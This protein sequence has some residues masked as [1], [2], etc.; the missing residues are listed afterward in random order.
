MKSIFKNY[1]ILC[2]ISLMLTG[3][4]EPEEETLSSEKIQV[5]TEVISTK[6]TPVEVRDTIRTLSIELSSGTYFIETRSDLL[7]SFDLRIFDVADSLVVSKNDILLGETVVLKDADAYQVA[8]IINNIYPNA[9]SADVFDST[10]VSIKVTKIGDINPSLNGYWYCSYET[11]TKEDTVLSQHF[12]LS[13]GPNMFR[14]AGDSLANYSFVRKGNR[15]NVDSTTTLLAESPFFNEMLNGV[16]SSWEGSNLVFTYSYDDGGVNLSGRYVFSPTNSN[17]LS[18][19]P[20][21]DSMIYEK[22]PEDLIGTWYFSKDI[23]FNFF[24]DGNG[25]FY[26]SNSIVYSANSSGDSHSILKFTQDS[27]FTFQLVTVDTPYTIASRSE[28]WAESYWINELDWLLIHEKSL[29]YYKC[30]DPGEI[31]INEFTKFEGEIPPLEWLEQVDGG[32]SKGN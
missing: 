7:I 15:F 20:V 32:V 23:M 30:L 10:N 31:W 6:K 26:N 18:L 25:G 14:L 12:E 21:V 22:V 4:F 3:C 16:E 17:P 1:L 2:F 11:H 28:S 5:N 27:V 9:D 13:D 19:T 29:S 24:A 8:I